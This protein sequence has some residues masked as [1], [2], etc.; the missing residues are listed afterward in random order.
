LEHLKKI[1]TML[2]LH[3]GAVAYI[4][5]GDCEACDHIL[6]VGNPKIAGTQSRNG[7]FRPHGL[8]TREGLRLRPSRISSWQVEAEHASHGNDHGRTDLGRR[9]ADDG[10]ADIVVQMKWNS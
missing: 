9:T 6:E 8:A 2:P 1:V 4:R 5:A 3:P 10:G 7:V